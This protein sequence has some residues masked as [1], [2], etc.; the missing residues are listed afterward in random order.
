M[1]GS[2]LQQP[3]CASGNTVPL[4]AEMRQKRFVI[5]TVLRNLA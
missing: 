2:L 5:A 1:A 4:P 3:D